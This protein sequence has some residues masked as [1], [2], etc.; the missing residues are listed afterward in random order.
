MLLLFEFEIIVLHC[1]H[2]SPLV[3]LINGYF[4]SCYDSFSVSVSSTKF[5]GSSPHV[6]DPQ[7]Q[8]G[9]HVSSAFAS[10]C[11]TGFA[12][13]LQQVHTNFRDMF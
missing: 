7:P 6:T 3:T 11:G 5:S 9:M 4:F 8:D 10:S 13:A 12:S 2:F 1:N